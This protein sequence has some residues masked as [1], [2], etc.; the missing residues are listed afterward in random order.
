M[1]QLELE[2]DSVQLFK[3]TSDR[4]WFSVD[5]KTSGR[6]FEQLHPIMNMPTVLAG[7]D[8]S[9]DTYI[10]QH[11]YVAPQ[12]LIA[13]LS[14]LSCA[15]ID[16]DYYKSDF[17]GF[18]ASFLVEQVLRRCESE[19][20]PN[21]SLI[22]DSGRG[23]YLK[24]LWTQPLRG[25]ALPRWQ[26]VERA[27]LKA[28]SDFGAD[29]GA[30]LG[31]QI[32]RIEGSRNTRS[33][34]TVGPI[35]TNGPRENP[36]RF[37]FDFFCDLVLPYSRADAQAYKASM[38]E[39]G[40]YLDRIH[41]NIALRNTRH[42]PRQRITDNISAVE[43][44]ALIEQDLAG[45]LWANR[46]AWIQRLATHRFG[47]N[48]VPDGDGRGS[49][50]EFCWLAANALAWQTKAPAEILATVRHLVPTYTAEQAKNSAAAVLNRLE[51]GALYKITDNH[52]IYRLAVTD[53]ELEAVGRPSGTSGRRHAARPG[54]GALKPALDAEL[55]KMRSL[56]FGM[57]L[58]QTRE[59]QSRGASYTNTVR[60]TTTRARIIN[61]I[62]ELQA[63][64]ESL[65]ASAIARKAG[66]DRAGMLRT[67]RD[68]LPR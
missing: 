45:E 22:I 27:L 15:H 58:E 13:T 7:L 41:K 49:R 68:L 16:V 4:A 35:W 8:Y 3:H 28:F 54:E 25:T 2:I 63:A 1:E 37:D 66:I 59:R 50:N 24:W 62:A 30:T 48:G 36:V 42:Y 34:R 11:C 19:E 56:E 46:Y 51:R 64:G 29:K 53:D 60:K 40:R 39:R 26:A 6:F 9:L 17:A 65:T 23:L 52:L 20:I 57:Y 61:A 14:A 32:L 47:F 38:A 55:G 33:G 67:H 21:P 5:Q 10:S 18:P 31:T 43:V 12:R 44:V